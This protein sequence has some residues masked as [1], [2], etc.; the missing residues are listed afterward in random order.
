MARF[1]FFRNTLIFYLFVCYTVLHAQSNEESDSMELT[2]NTDVPVTKEHT[3]LDTNLNN[4]EKSVVIEDNPDPNEIAFDGEDSNDSFS[5]IDKATLPDDFDSD[6]DRENLIN[7]QSVDIVNK[8][9][10][11]D[12]GKDGTGNLTVE[13]DG[14][15]TMAM[16]ASHALNGT[17]SANLTA[18]NS[19]KPNIRWPCKPYTMLS[20]NETL[21]PSV[22]IIN[23]ETTLGNVISSMNGTKECGVMLFY[24]PYCEFCTNLAPLYNAV[25]RSYSNLIVIASDA[26]KVMGMSA[27]YGIVGIPTILLFYSGKAVAKYNRSRTVKDFEQFIVELTGLTP[28]IGFNIT[29]DDQL[30]PISSKP[31]ESRD[32]YLIFSVAFV[33]IFIIGK[34][35]GTCLKNSCI[36]IFNRLKTLMKRQKID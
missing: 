36:R 32:Y 15:T 5:D 34:L 24:S 31:K 3:S 20:S 26:Q 14:N 16:N 27:R 7:G 18:I 35:L 25:G 28:S 10:I 17:F 23:N 12:F 13:S 1:T 30:G 29:S 6:D 11:N 4:D 22:V 9:N 33:V 2:F 19:S 21:S 8:F